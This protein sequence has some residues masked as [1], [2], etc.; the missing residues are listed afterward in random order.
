M[1][2]NQVEMSLQKIRAL[3]EISREKQEM[4]G[5]QCMMVAIV[6]GDL[7]IIPMVGMVAMYFIDMQDN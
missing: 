5:H 4:D 2:L 6:A 3:P 7:T 1:L